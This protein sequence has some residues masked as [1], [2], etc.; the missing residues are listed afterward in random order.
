MKASL[1]G[2]NP[3]NFITALELVKKGF[4]VDILYLNK[5]KKTNT[6]R[7]L[8]ISKNN[9]KFLSQNLKQIHNFSWPITKIKIFNQKNNLNE[10]MD[11]SNKN[12]KI[13]F[14]N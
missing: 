3:T 13:F 14:F 10:F 6:N 4:V 12:E 5:S 8:G 11:F 7:T 9:F 2:Y 1:I